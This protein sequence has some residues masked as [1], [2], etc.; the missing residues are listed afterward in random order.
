ML[1][2][3]FAVIADKVISAKPAADALAEPFVVHQRIQATLRSSNKPVEVRV[4]TDAE[5]ARNEINA[6]RQGLENPHL[7]SYA[8]TFYGVLPEIDNEPRLYFAFERNLMPL[9]EVH[10]VSCCFG[11]L[12]VYVCVCVCVFFCFFCL[13]FF[14]FCKLL[15][16]NRT[17]RR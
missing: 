5:L 10:Q 3:A 7:L 4:L 2:C 11:L 15:R 17:A 16:S 6:V 13:F 8:N 12:C 1:R 14:A 9:S